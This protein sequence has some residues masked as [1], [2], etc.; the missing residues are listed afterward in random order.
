MRTWN[1]LWCE[2][3]DDDNADYVAAIRRIIIASLNW[4]EAHPN[5]TP[6][7]RERTKR[8][9]MR[10]AGIPDAVAEDTVQIAAAWEDVYQP[11]NS[12]T[13]DWFR[14][15]EQ[16]CAKGDPKGKPSSHMMGKGVAAG[17]LLLRLG[18]DEF[19]AFMLEPHGD[20][21]AH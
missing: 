1:P 20:T 18:W 5:V 11:R 9:V 15:M 6:Q 14:A 19:N 16:A 7:W 4:I 17:A 3:E 8:S 21:A 10:Q 12:V 13:R 2:P